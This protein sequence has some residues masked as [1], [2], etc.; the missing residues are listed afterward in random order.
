MLITYKSNENN[1]LSVIN[2]AFYP[3]HQPDNPILAGV[4][5]PGMVFSVESYVGARNGHEGFKL[6][7]QIL[8]TENGSE[9]LSDMEFKDYL[10]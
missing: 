7:Q 1:G 4:V 10:L 8:V 2:L 9:L 6:E 3:V 5:E